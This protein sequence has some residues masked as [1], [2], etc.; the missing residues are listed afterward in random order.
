MSKT[1][2]NKAVAAVMADL[3]EWQKT[4][5]NMAFTIIDEISFSS[6]DDT[7]AFLNVSEKT[8]RVYMDLTQRQEALEERAKLANLRYDL[9]QSSALQ[10]LRYGIAK[11]EKRGR[12]TFDLEVCHSSAPSPI[13]FVG[14]QVPETPTPALWESGGKSNIVYSGPATGIMSLTASATATVLKRVMI[15]GE[16][17]AGS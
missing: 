12:G 10:W 9:E 14:P 7:S 8:V 3:N 13:M 15:R 11:I 17:K 1:S 16:V 5:L 2:F 6:L 4:V